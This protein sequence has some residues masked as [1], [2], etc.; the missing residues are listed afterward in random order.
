MSQYEFS[1]SAQVQYLPEES[2]PERRQY[3]FA[4][5]LTI[6]NTGQVPAQFIARHWVITDSEKTCRK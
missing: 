3:A 2:D 1:V 4:Y 6:R 5:T